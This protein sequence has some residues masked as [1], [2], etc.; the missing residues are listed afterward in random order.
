MLFHHLLF[1]DIY[2]YVYSFEISVLTYRDA[3]THTFTFISLISARTGVKNIAND[4]TNKAYVWLLKICLIRV[5]L[6]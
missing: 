5:R 3:D 4:W 1:L 2:N 6:H